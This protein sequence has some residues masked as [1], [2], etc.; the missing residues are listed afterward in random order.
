MSIR[1]FLRVFTPG[2]WRYRAQRASEMMR[3]VDFMRIIEAHEVGLD[4]TLAVHSSPSG[5]KYLIRALEA[6]AIAPTDRI[7]DIGCGKGSAM[8][9][10]LKFPFAAVDGA[11]LSEEIASIARANFVAL[12]VPAGRCKVCAADATALRTELDGYSH[13][14]MYNPFR[15]PIMK[16]V[17]ANLSESLDRH[18]RSVSLLYNTPACRADI[19][20]TG[21]FEV[22]RRFEGVDGAEM[23]WY[24]S[25]G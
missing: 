1:R 21:R 13:F 6:M 4:P 15:S 20:A 10:M 18:P 19:D 9:V 22:V 23:L 17:A 3:G 11:E 25:R 8:S 12:G 2:P 5:N 24:R 7:L 14:Y 16:Q